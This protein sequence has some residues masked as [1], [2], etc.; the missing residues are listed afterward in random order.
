MKKFLFL[1]FALVMTFVANAKESAW[2]C[3]DHAEDYSW[4]CFVYDD[5]QQ[6]TTQYG[7]YKVWVKW[8]YATS[9]AQAEFDTKARI[10]KQLYEISHDFTEYRILQV[11]DYDNESKVIRERNIPSTWSYIVPETIGSAIVLTAKD[12]ILKHD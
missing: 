11:N 2:I 9:S 4:W 8:E 1:A 10:S 7:Y 12:I 6:P 3:A 5:I